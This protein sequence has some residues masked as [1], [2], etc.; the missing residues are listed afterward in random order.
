MIKSPGFIRPLLDAWFYID[1]KGM[2]YGS[3]S[4]GWVWDTGSMTEINAGLPPLA[5][6]GLINSSLN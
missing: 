2:V 3:C 1:L 6:W 4:A 5:A